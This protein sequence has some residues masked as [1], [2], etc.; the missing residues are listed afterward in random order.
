MPPA[1]PASFDGPSL[2]DLRPPP[3]DGPAAELAASLSSAQASIAPKF[4]YDPLGSAVFAAICALPEY[5]PTRTERA[6]LQDHGDA[7]ARAAGRGCT[8]VD[9]GAGDCRKAESLFGLLAPSQY[10]AVDVSGDYLRDALQALA[11][12]HRGIDMMGVAA[13][14]SAGLEL[15]PAV[16]R[17]RLFF[18]PGSSIGNF[19][20]SAAGAFLSGL[21]AAMDDEGGLLLG[22]DLVK[23][24][25]VLQAAYDDAVGLTA[26]FNR[27]ALLAANRVL[28]ANFDPRG[29]DHVALWNAQA[30]RVEMHLEARRAVEVRWPGGSRAFAA[31]ERIHTENSYK[32]TPDAIEGLL[33]A[34]GLRCTH[35]W[36]DPQ[37]WF[38]VLLARPQK[39]S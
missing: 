12:R 32:Y 29:W 10:V 18:Y 3:A 16:G 37:G 15:P 17:R 28:G 22:V 13:D 8:L 6:I 25:A 38:A 33:A 36:L 35:R 30:S 23:P 21:R 1:E 34:A 26:A 24:A 4:F 5:Y 39:R 27:N 2:L 9:L 31:G 20:P 14:F 19:E 7:I 11:Q